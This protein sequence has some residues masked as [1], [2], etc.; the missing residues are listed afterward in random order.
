MFDTRKYHTQRSP[1]THT[2]HHMFSWRLEPSL[3]STTLH[4]MA[5]FCTVKASFSLAAQRP[6]RRH[7]C[8]SNL[9]LP[10]CPEVEAGPSGKSTF[11]KSQ[12][13]RG[14]LLDVLK[15]PHGPSECPRQSPLCC[16][17]CTLVCV[18]TGPPTPPSLS[19]MCLI[20]RERKHARMLPFSSPLFRRF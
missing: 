13:V 1:S 12:H 15:A 8:L 11:I 14:S 18:E 9:W 17:A 10:G 5:N 16:V 2:T 6:R 19:S 4:Q 7:A 20:N 3:D